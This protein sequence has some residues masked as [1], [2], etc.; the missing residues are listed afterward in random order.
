MTTVCQQHNNLFLVYIF[1][2]DPALI[3][4]GRVDMKEKIDWATE[5]QLEQMFLR[6]Y[7]EESLAR[8]AVFA[9][10]ALSHGK[11][12][13][14]AQVQGLFLVYKTDPQAVIDGTGQLWTL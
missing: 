14:L 8:A 5:H 11:N 2:L 7:P 13:S 9:Q 12:V 1:R 3:R 10:N 6:F 4:P